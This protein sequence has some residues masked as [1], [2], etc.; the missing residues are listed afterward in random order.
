MSDENTQQE[1]TFGICE[2]GHPGGGLPAS[3]VNFAV[4]QDD[5]ISRP[6]LLMPFDIEEGEQYRL[7]LE[8]DATGFEVR[9]GKIGQDK[10][11]AQVKTRT[12]REEQELV[13]LCRYGEVFI[14]G[15]PNGLSED[16]SIRADKPTVCKI[17][18]YNYWNRVKT[19]LDDLR[20]SDPDMAAS[21]ADQIAS[22]PSWNA[23]LEKLEELGRIMPGETAKAIAGS[24]LKPV[25]HGA[26]PVGD[27]GFADKI[28]GR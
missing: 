26:K 8:A 9:S 20:T 1:Q 24:I 28:K 4:D 10:V 21:I 13:N 27:G 16:H 6:I 19:R 23:H 14:V 25:G 7:I 2:I 11:L 5:I 3:Q 17:D 12:G 22:N 15:A 18:D